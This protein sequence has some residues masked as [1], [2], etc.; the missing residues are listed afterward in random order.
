M[1][2]VACIIKLRLP[3]GQQKTVSEMIYM[4]KHLHCSPET[5]KN[6]IMTVGVEMCREKTSQLIW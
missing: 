3:Q 6:L 5:F 2:D 4:D 1:Q